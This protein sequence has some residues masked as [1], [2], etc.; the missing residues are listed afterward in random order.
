MMSK[1]RVLVAFFAFCAASIS[2]EHVTAQSGTRSRNV[3]QQ[4]SVRQGS[5]LRGSYPR[6]IEQQPITGQNS[7]R[8]TV[9]VQAP[10]VSQGSSTRSGAAA[11]I[12]PSPNSFEAKFW[13]YLLDSKY[14]N[15]APMPGK[16]DGFAEG[17][18][19]HGALIKIYM[20]RT[21]AA[22]PMEMPESSI[23]VK[24][25]FSPAKELKAI[26]VMYKTNGWYWIK[27]FPNG[28]VGTGPPEKGG[29]KLA[30]RVKSCID[31]HAA[32]DGGD[33]VFEND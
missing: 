27:Y 25:N 15:W 14:R 23:I 3:V 30:G 20:N 6:A 22:N 13:Q 1:Q 12:T 17:G 33:Y 16:T 32:A 18:S 9:Q 5:Q 26:T 24:E 8:G 7:R 4:P 2:T 21:A 31:C 29:M 19:P 11:G 10:A 28:N